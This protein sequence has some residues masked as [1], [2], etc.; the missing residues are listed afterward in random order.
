MCEV[1]DVGKALQE[2]KR[3]LRPGG[4]WVPF[5]EH[6]SSA[7]ASGMLT[8]AVPDSCMPLPDSC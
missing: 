5:V 4:K 6:Y 8:H 1:R 3:V 2:I 7:C